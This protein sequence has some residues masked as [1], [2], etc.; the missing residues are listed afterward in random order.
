MKELGWEELDVI[1]VTGDS[2]ID[3]PFIGAAVIGKLLVSHGFRVGII[4]QPDYRSHS[5]IRRL[6]EP[7]LFWGVT[8]GSVDSMVANYTAT[9]K[10]RKQDDFTPGGKNRRRPDRA[11]IVYTNLI[12][13]TFRNTSPIV[14]GGIEASLRRLAHYDFWSDSIRRSVLLDA[15]A[16]LLVYG[17]GEWAICR[18]AE[19]LA[20]GKPYHDIRGICYVAHQPPEGFVTLPS[21][22]AVRNCRSSF[23]NMFLEF[24]QNNNVTASPGMIQPYGSR[25]LVHNP[26]APP[27]GS[28]ELDQIHEMEYERELHPY[29]RREGQVRALDTIRF[30]IISHRG[31]F[32]ECRFCAIALH[33]GNTVCSRSQDSIL[34]EARS[35]LRHPLFRGIISDVGGPT[36]NMY[37]LECRRSRKKNDCTRRQCI[38]PQICGKMNIDHQKQID[39]LQQLRKIP[40]IRHVF[41]ASGIRHDLILADRNNG[42]RYLT[43]LISHHLSG[44]MK[45]APE[46]SETDILE[47]MGKP[48]INILMDFKELFDRL[49][50]Q[51]S[52]PRYLTYYLMAAHPG[53]TEEHMQ[54]LSWFCENRLFTRPEQIQIF[55]PTP[56]TLSTLMYYTGIH[57]FTGERLFVEKRTNGKQN[58]KNLIRRPRPSPKR[59]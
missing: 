31:C 24:Q 9:L 55:T 14:L 15:K 54:K 49:V 17:M 19:A 12:R 58:Q 59:G 16:D 32:G 36:A 25:Y 41:I 40:G 51:S 45:L 18:L 42:S 23:Q 43:E 6:G 57:P 26:P 48:E 2:Y 35:F 27:L 21:Y 33:Q 7:R 3:S 5:D 53:C 38:R 8:A 34:R 28:E 46:H 50:R 37:G 22:E 1:L 56:S 44:Q 47:L 52:V 10:P 13:S 39:L 30:S 11:V 4:A 20:Q 29:Y